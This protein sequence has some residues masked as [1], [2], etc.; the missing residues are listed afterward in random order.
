MRSKIGGRQTRHTAN[1]L[2]GPHHRGIHDGVTGAVH[3]SASD[4]GAIGTEATLGDS[5]TIVSFSDGAAIG[6]ATFTALPLG[7]GTIPEPASLGL[8]VLGATALISRR[9]R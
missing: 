5:M 2:Y 1:R 8:L 7:G 9:K 4:N 6:D 3:Q